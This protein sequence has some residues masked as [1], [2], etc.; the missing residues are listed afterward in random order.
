[1]ALL[2]SFIGML[3]ML[4]AASAVRL[5]STS[6]DVDTYIVHMDSAAMPSAFSGRRS[7]YAATL[8]AT[9]DASDAIPA[10]EKIVYVYD[11]AIH[12][13]SARLSSAQLEQL[14]KSH[15]FLSCSRDAPVKK[16]TTHTSDFLQLSASAGL[17]PASNYGEDVIIGVLDTGIWPESASFRDDGLTAVPSRWRGACEQGTAFSSSACN[18][19]L[20]GARSFNKGLLA[21]DPNLTIAVNSPRDTDGHGTHTSSTAGGNYVE[22]ASFFGYASG[23]ARGMAPRARLAMYKVLWDEGAVTSDIIAGIDQ[24]I[25]DGVDVISMSFGLDGV[26]LYEDPIA[27]ASFAAVQKGIFV[28][29]SAGNEG[30]FLGFLHNGTPWVLTVGAGT[31]DREFAAVIGLGDG[32]LVIG[33]SLYPGNPATLKQMP[34]AFLGSC[35]NTTLLKK[36]RHKIVVCQADELGGAIQYLRYAKVDAGLFISNDSFSQLYSQFSFPAAIIS[37]QDGP[38]ILNYIQT[39][40]EPKANITFRLTVLGTKPA[41][42][43]ATYTSRG[44]SASCPNVL[45]PDVVAPGSLILASWAQ[46]STVGRVGTHKLYGPFAIISGTS[47]A[48]PHASGVSASLKAARPGWS[49]AAIRSALMTTASHLDNTGAPIKD[50]GNGNKQASPLAMGA[51]HIDPNRALEPG[52]VYDAGT[53]D[54]VNLLCAMN[55]TSKQLK[56]ITGTATV[57]CSNPTLDLN[58]PSFIAYFDP[59]ETS[60][61]APSVRQFRRTVTNVGDNPVATY[62]AKLVDIKGFTVSVVPEKLSFKEKYQ[63]QSFTLT[64]KENTREKKDA[65]RHGSLTW[66]DDKEKYVVRSPIV[67]T[68][69]SPISL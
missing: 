42:T 21:S 12:G 64:L 11:H 67:A 62:T 27:V 22:G 58:Y 55:F 49:P 14:K 50:M 52:L 57:D 44:P 3:W 37:P 53:E 24:A 17:W 13:F 25:S 46:N 1:M 30:P 51:G 43:V 35:N 23:V 66:V 29:T 65:V 26:A 16:D 2:E 38:T 19:K 4:L 15:G 63:K 20:I 28:S 61:S 41:P 31:V 36:T 8:A 10:D 6:A 47:M 33:Q 18:R 40:S 54:Y 5:A 39:S 60:A 9:A 68:T 48:C 7:W 45:K 69:V 56:T 59:N 32:T 34:M